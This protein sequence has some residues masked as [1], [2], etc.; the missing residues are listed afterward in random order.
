MLPP[1]EDFDQR[2]S[3]VRR[4]REAEALAERLRRRGHLRARTASFLRALAD[5]LA[6]APSA[7]SADGEPARPRLLLVHPANR[8]TTELHR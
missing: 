1:Y 3:T 8:G 6:P 5:R 7:P 4:Q 2:V